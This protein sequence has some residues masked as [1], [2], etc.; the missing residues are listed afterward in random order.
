[1]PDDRFIEVGRLDE[2]VLRDYAADVAAAV[3]LARGEGRSPAQS[4]GVLINAISV[5]VC[6]SAT[7]D[8][9]PNQI[10]WVIEHTR[11]ALDANRGVVAG[12]DPDRG[13]EH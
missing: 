4:I 3:R 1:M 6:S 9:R 2:A 12:E 5:I 11:A 7:L 10:E 8:E 13:T